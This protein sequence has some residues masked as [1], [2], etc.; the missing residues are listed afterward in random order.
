M[1]MDKEPIETGLDYTYRVF[2]FEQINGATMNIKRKW[3][4]YNTI[5]NELNKMGETKLINEIKYRI[6]DNE[7]DKSVFKTSLNKIK[8]KNEILN[9][10]LNSI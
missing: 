6:T 8:N 1:M 2:V 3:V 7:N 10:L 4:T 5:L 9:L